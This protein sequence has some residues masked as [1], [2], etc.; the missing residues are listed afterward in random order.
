ML[1]LPMNLIKGVR[2]A[3]CAAW[4]KALV[5]YIVV[6][7]RA[8]WRLKSCDN[9]KDRIYFAMPTVVRP[10]IGMVSRSSIFSMAL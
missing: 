1:L 6:L 10:E 9:G 2:S 8:Q 4:R 7:C 5:A 3:C